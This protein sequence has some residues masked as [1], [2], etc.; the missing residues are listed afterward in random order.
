[1]VVRTR[2]RWSLIKW[3]LLAVV[4][5][6]GFAAVK[7]GW[8]GYGFSQ[9]KSSL[10][11]RD[12]SVLEWMPL[13]T[14]AVAI[15][16]PHQIRPKDAVAQRT[17]IGATLM[18]LR[19]DVLKVTGVDLAFDVDKIALAPNLAVLRGRFDGEKLATKLAEYRYVR[20]EYVGRAYLVRA[21]ED[22]VMASDDFLIYGDEASLRAAIDASAGASLAKDASFTARLERM[23]WNH[24]LLASISLAD[25]RPSIRTLITGTTGPRAV[26]LGVRG[27]DAL[28]ARASVE[29][30]SASA[31]LD[32]AKLLESERSRAA[33]LLEPWAGEPLASQLAALAKDATVRPEPGAGQVDIHARIPADSLDAILRA[34]EQSAAVGRAAKT[35]P[36][37]QLLAPAP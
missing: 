22:A 7:M 25:D 18:R 37:Y 24:P 9:L 17:R 10:W 31:A 36:L 33:E 32:L 16:D 15:F 6:T 21:G 29:A 34:T 30:S 1:M 27:G 13:T 19:A 14:T 23:G 4:A 8:A 11:P 35:L 3:A 2:S 5:L 20:A 28:D 12:E 26:T